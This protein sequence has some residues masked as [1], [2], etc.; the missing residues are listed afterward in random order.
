M[1]RVYRI[2][3]KDK[4]K[5]M[6]SNNTLVNSEP[7]LTKHTHRTRKGKLQNFYKQEVLLFLVLSEFHLPF[8]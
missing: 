1:I 3:T 2:R 4:D 5:E 7:I 6:A 8:A